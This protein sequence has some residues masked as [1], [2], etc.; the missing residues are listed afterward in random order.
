MKTIT[1]A[2]AFA[3]YMAVVYHALSSHDEK[4]VMVSRPVADREEAEELAAALRGSLDP[5]R[6]TVAVRGIRGGQ[7]LEAVFSSLE[8][9]KG[10]NQ[11]VPEQLHAIPAQRG[12]E[13]D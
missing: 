3:M 12:I 2:V 5:G 11:V 13:P 10:S 7:G 4:P 1:K 9:L 6:F 8:Q